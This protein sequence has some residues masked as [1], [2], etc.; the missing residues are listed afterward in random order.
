MTVIN[1]YKIIK[2]K[3][4]ILKE[5]I[6]KTA[7]ESSADIKKDH[8]QHVQSEKKDLHQGELVP[9]KSGSH[10]T[11]LKGQSIG[12]S[13]PGL[14]KKDQFLVSS[15]LST[16]N[17]FPKPNRHIILLIMDKI[18]DKFCD[19]NFENWIPSNT[20]YDKDFESQSIYSYSILLNILNKIIRTYPSTASLIALFKSK[21]LKNFKSF[22]DFLVKK[23]YPLGFLKW[24]K[25][26]INN[27]LKLN[28]LEEIWKKSNIKGVKNDPKTENN[29]PSYRVSWDK[30]IEWENI[31]VNNMRTFIDY[32]VYM[33]HQEKKV[34]LELK[35][36]FISALL[37]KLN[38]ISNHS[39]L[40]SVAVL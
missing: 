35:R 30:N 31:I 12:A 36:Q 11:R 32:N 1:E 29:E 17:F 10:T 15:L 7:K 2:L 21:K 34:K 25:C 28:K 9:I 26:D 8:I 38:K 23:I 14:S 20:L 3:D 40:K 4:S 22:I 16:Q 24:M 37:E 5:Y 18:V 13:T 27:D 6:T 39:S 33:S 19:G